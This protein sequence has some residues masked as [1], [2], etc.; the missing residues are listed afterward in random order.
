MSKETQPW[1]RWFVEIVVIVFSILLAFAIEAWWD[2][3]QEREDEREILAGLEREFIS[4]RDKLDFALRRHAEMQAAMEDLI[5]AT[6]T[7]RWSSDNFT[8]D[9]AITRSMWPPTTE[10]GGGVRDALVQ[11]GRLEV[12]T[13]RA[14]RERLAGWEGVAA[15]I[16]DDEVFSRDMVFQ[17]LM[18]HLAENG[19]DLSS[20]YRG[21]S[22]DKITNNLLGDNPAES[23]RLFADRTYRALLQLRLGYW[24]HAEMEYQ[25]GQQA[26]A[27]IL[28]LILSAQAGLEAG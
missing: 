22:G 10:L 2:E 26:V 24:R 25:A 11:A 19:Y 21:V 23:Q 17:Q 4:Y 20:V 13:N 7:G 6:E 18:P 16:I 1:Q 8:L 3:R 27:E 5:L 28:E 14:L 15:E 9:E 12:I